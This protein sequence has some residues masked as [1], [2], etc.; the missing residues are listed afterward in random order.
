MRISAIVVNFR[1]SEYVRRC[2]ASLYEAG[3]ERVSLVDNYSS[4]EERDA[5]K[6][7]ADAATVDV[8]FTPLNE[9][10]G[11]G[12]GVNRGVES[13]AAAD[14]DLI[15]IVNPDAEVNPGAVR[16]LE[17]RFASD[18]ADVVSPLILTGSREQAHVWFGGGAVLE[19]QGRTVHGRFGELPY[20]L[21]GLAPASF[22]TGA[23]P[24]MRA[25]TFRQLGGFR[26]DLFLY[27]EDTDFSRR[28]IAEGF[29][30]AV[31]SDARIW[32]AV[33]GSGDDSGKSAVYYYYMQRNRMLVAAPWTSRWNLLLG[34]GAIETMKL[35]LR[36]LREKSEK[37]AKARASVRGLIEGFRRS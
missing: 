29:R 15:W 25:S 23:A 21:S 28:A 35:T 11:F 19:A 17:R 31:D 22:L 14:A 6:Q 5:V 33:G 13:L 7:I 20:G 32:H 36:P 30:L 1:S 37:L 9:N 4:D 3:V 12:A 16:S 34:R 10:I 26:E 24:M 27:W 18:R 8:I 2:L